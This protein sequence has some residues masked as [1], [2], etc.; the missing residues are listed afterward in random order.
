ML[1]Q[2]HISGTRHNAVSAD[3]SRVIFT[4]PDPY[5]ENA[6]GSGGCWNGKTL[7]SPAALHARGAA[8]RSR[9]L[10]PKQG[11]PEGGRAPFR[12]LR[13]CLRRRLRVFFLTE[14]ELTK[15]DEG[16]HDPELY[17][18][19]SRTVAQANAPKPEAV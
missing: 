2:G 11:G 18:W 10:R 14:A 5:A 16:I 9:S 6:E 8:R 13:R 3:G 15:D 12:R 4:A 17:E 7:N 19:R 1:G